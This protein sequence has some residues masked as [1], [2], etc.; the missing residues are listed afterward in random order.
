[1]RI[2]TIVYSMQGE[3]GEK[4]GPITKGPESTANQPGHFF[5]GNR[6]SLVECK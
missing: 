2:N 6:K 1:M 5:E 4:S 3:L